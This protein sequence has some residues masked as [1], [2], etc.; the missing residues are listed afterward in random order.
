MAKKLLKA[1][2]CYKKHSSPEKEG[3]LGGI[4]IENW[5]LQHGGSLKRAAEDFMSVAENCQTYD[6][7][8]R[9]YSI[10][11]FGQ[12]HYALE[13]S[14][15]SHDDFVYKNM[16]A[17]GYERMKAALKCYLEYGMKALDEEVAT[18]IVNKVNKRVMGGNGYSL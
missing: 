6:E 15:Y 10:W 3:G 12:N 18:E 17:A 4:G 8:K 9:Q 11:D 7:F 13:G 14:N 1:Y 2:K 16:D 5:I